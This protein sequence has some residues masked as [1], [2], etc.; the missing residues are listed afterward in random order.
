MANAIYPKGKQNM[1]SGNIALLTD[2]VKVALVDSAVYTYNAAHEFLSDVASTIATSPAL[3][4]KTVT[5]GA[6]D[7]DDPVFSAVG[8]GGPHEYLIFYVDSGAAATSEL[9]CFI[10]TATGL[11]VTPNGTDITVQIGTH[12]FAI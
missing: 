6:F 11:P 10:D 7:A 4:T 9:L 8:A 3:T 1:L 12:I 2:A 5:D